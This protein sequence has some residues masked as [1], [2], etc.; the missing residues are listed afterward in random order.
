MVAFFRLEQREAGKEKMV[1]TVQ[2]RDVK[3]AR[4]TGAVSPGRDREEKSGIDEHGKSPESVA[5]NR[6]VILK[7]DKAAG[8]EIDEEFERF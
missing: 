4:E 7:M 5:G 8:D 1:R 3:N 2:R 6:G